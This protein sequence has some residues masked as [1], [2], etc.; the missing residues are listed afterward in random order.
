MD[1]NQWES[2]SALVA[3]AKSK[4]PDNRFDEEFDTLLLRLSIVVDR[5]KAGLTVD[6]IKNTPVEGSDIAVGD[7]I[8]ASRWSDC[9]P[10]DPWAVG[11]VVEVSA[12]RVRFEAGGRGYQY[13]MRITPEQGERIVRIM[14]GLEGSSPD[15]AYIA[16]L[17]LGQG[18]FRTTD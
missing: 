3:E 7:Y 9:S 15:A 10:N 14:P 18:A 13:A 5:R 11:H 8:F 2:V 17:F 16:D 12:G 6:Q 1:L 4:V